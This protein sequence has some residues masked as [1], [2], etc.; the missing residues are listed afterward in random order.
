VLLPVFL[1][2]YASFPG[3]NARSSPRLNDF[4]PRLYEPA[5]F[6][7]RG[8]NVPFTT[9]MLLGARARPQEDKSGLEV[10]ISNP[11][12]DSS[13]YILPWV[14][15]PQICTPTL[16]DRR[17]WQLLRDEKTLT[18]R[19]V[20]EAAETAALEG[21]AGRGAA[22]A[23]QGA[24]M[25][26]EAREK[27]VNFALLL[28]LIKRT[29][30]PNPE[31]P[32]PELD[33]PRQLMV[34][35]QRAVAQSAKQLHTTTAGVASAL[36][37][38]SKAFSGLGLPQDNQPAPSRQLLT[39]LGKLTH[40]ISSWREDLPE[41]ATSTTASLVQHSVELTLN[42]AL[43]SAK[44]V[45]SLIGDT[46]AALE[47]WR[48]DSDDVSQRLTRLDWLLDGWEMITGIW[49]AASLQEKTSAIM[50]MA[51]LAPIL[52]KEVTGWYGV[53][54]DWA[55]TRR[56]NRIVQQFE[57]WRSG[58]LVD[59]IARNEELTI[60]RGESQARMTS[61]LRK[62][63][64]KLRVATPISEID[65]DTG[66]KSLT[67]KVHRAKTQLAETR[68]LIHALAGASDMAL[69]NVVE[70]LDRLPDRSEADR[71]LDAA[72]PRL[73]Q[74]RPPRSLQLTRLL[75]LPLDGA[76]VDNADWQRGDF[77]LPRAA[78]PGIAEALRMV[79][80]G[81]VQKLEASFARKTFQDT[82][83]VDRAGRI[84]WSAAAGLASNLKPGPRWAD[85]GFRPEDFHSLVQLAAGVWRHAG[86]VWAA[87]QLSGW[88]PPDEAVRAALAPMAEE[89][90]PAFGM[91]LATLMQNATNPGIVAQVAATLSDR[92]GSIADAAVD[93]WLAKARVNLPAQDL[94]AAA[95]MAESF[96]HAFQDLENA[97][98]TRNPN[99]AGRL[100]HLRQEA[101][102]TCRLAYEE[103]L[104]AEIMQQLPFL[105]SSA[106]HDQVVVL[107]SRARALRRIELVGRRYGID[108]GYE[109]SAKRIGEA[110]RATKQTL[111]PAGLTK[112]DLARVAEI[113]LGP[114]AALDALT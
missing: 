104:E 99:R 19:L 11:S 63:A 105:A 83:L 4:N 13:V 51:L 72:R 65:H 8:V 81:E 82:G 84:V 77:R 103:G 16:H 59:M 112:L 7:D 87:I 14:A 109:G 70:L 21:L 5:T 107:E 17:L 57:D 18:P 31:K 32:P 43:Q 95:T 108:H 20:R 55:M 60:L 37:E 54:P 28:D 98:A 46:L 52:P 26:R 114:E 69:T 85:S 22:S 53:E 100:V 35:S 97:P 113:L 49:N 50:E 15:I 40:S 33:D 27:R 91:C 42:C 6:Y 12:G 93:D 10:I 3:V 75:F 34:R 2:I 39:E 23:V 56:A 36:E 92:A 110:L 48:A 47:A 68:H 106:T 78:L 111:T 96:G 90:S 45:D 102:M 101:E 44:E 61:I 64:Q 86:P 74:L 67:G 88:G 9:P 29:E 94:L 80:G 79:L 62:G 76:I 38:L 71:L 41:G 89:D 58:R 24:R 73:R 1:R 25:A 30:G 66:R